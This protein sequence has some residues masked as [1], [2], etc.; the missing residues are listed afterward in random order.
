MN[1]AERIVTSIAQRI[2]IYLHEGKKVI[3]IR[4]GEFHWGEVI[5]S[6]VFSGHDK[7]SNI[8][9]VT[10][11]N[12]R[13]EAAEALHVSPATIQR[14]LSRGDMVIYRPPGERK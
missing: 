6:T 4:N 14:K 13:N 8:D 11:I 2:G 1:P 3:F 12:I 10:R 7:L 9:G 5:G